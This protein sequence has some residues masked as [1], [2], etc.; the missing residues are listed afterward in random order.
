MQFTVSSERL[1]EACLMD[2]K[3]LVALLMPLVLLAVMYPIF[4][5]TARK[6][7]NTVGWHSGLLIYWIIW[8]VVYP[9]AVLGKETILTMIRPQR[10]EMN[11][12][13]LAAIPVIFA[14]PGRIFFGMEY[15][16]TTV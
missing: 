11:A 16:K 14:A 10:I 15:E 2:S 1:Y 3:K 5:L 13:L 8:G 9:L 7:G 12:V 4:Q 6:Y